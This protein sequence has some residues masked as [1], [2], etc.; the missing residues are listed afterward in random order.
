M[1]GIFIGLNQFWE[2]TI[3]FLQCCCVVTFL[4]L[5]V[6][7][8]L[9]HFLQKLPLQLPSGYWFFGGV[10]QRRLCFDNKFVNEGRIWTVMDFG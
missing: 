6:Y 9:F 8:Y 4:M 2:Q 5:G 10:S 7:L 3:V 1:N